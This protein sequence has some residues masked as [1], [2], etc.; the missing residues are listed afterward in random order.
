[1][2][3]DLINEFEHAR[4]CARYINSLLQKAE[5]KSQVKLITNSKDEVRAYLSLDYTDKDTL[6]TLVNRNL[7]KTN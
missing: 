4:Y 7:G 5:V 6:S 1:M 2:D 3:Q